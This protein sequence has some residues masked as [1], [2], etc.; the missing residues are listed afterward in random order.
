[1]RCSARGGDGEKGCV[2]GLC[3]GRCEVK[4]DDKGNKDNR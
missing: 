4:K 3:A 2:C 1:M